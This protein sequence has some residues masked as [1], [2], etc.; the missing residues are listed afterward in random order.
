MQDHRDFNFGADIE[1]SKRSHARNMHPKHIEVLSPDD[2]WPDAPC[3]LVR[4]WKSSFFTSAARLV[5][6]ATFANFP[7]SPTF[8]QLPF[9][10]FWHNSHIACTKWK[11]YMSAVFVTPIR[12]SW[13]QEV[14][15][16]TSPKKYFLDQLRRCLRSTS[17]RNSQNCI[18]PIV[19]RK[20]HEQ[21]QFL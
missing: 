6:F 19:H 9:H 7:N 18:V 3:P 15:S 16:Y 1:T 8:D 11:V 17:Y 5:F 21:I 13:L 4:M 2:Q 20:K 14:K 12:P 10:Q